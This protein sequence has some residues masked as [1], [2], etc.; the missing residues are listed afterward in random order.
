DADPVRAADHARAR[1]CADRHHEETAVR[2]LLL[3]LLLLV[4]GVAILGA[5][6]QPLD[7]IVAIVGTRPILASQVEEEMVQQQAQGAQLPTDPAGLAALRRQ[8]L[9]RLIELEVLVQQAERD[10][11]IKVTDQEVLDQVEQTYQNVRKQFSS[12]SDFRDQIRQ[13]RFG[14]VEEWR[15]WLADEQ[16]RQLYAQR[17]I[18]TQRQ[19]GK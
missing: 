14:S 12:E 18:E 19:K 11:S 10:T 13:A 5:Q 16:R 4:S 6:E 15:R 3:A 8:I 9:D 1:A 2:K 17:L 7:R